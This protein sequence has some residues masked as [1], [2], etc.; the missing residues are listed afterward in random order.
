MQLAFQIDSRNRAI[1]NLLLNACGISCLLLYFRWVG[2]SVVRAFRLAAG[3]DELPS[4]LHSRQARTR[5][6]IWTSEHD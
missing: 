2:T 3:Y 5:L 6:T 1:L 4:L